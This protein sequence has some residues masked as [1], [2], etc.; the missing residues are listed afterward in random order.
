[1]SFVVNLVA[2]FVA[3][4]VVFGIASALFKPLQKQPNESKEEH[5]KRIMPW[6]WG[7]Y[8]ACLLFLFATNK[9]KEGVKETKKEMKVEAK[10]SAEIDYILTQMGI[11]LKETGSYLKELGSIVQLGVFPSN[12]ESTLTIFIQ[13]WNKMKQDLDSL[14]NVPASD[15]AVYNLMQDVT[16]CM[17]DFLNEAHNIVSL[18]RTGNVPSIMMDSLTNKGRLCSDKMIELKRNIENKRR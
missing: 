16:N 9:P 6:F 13:K 14:R 12:T 15:Y 4:I 1:M 11:L 5:G 10:E 2:G 17:L 7:I 8:F 3:A 18:S